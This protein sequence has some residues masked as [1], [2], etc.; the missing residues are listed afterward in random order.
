MVMMNAGRKL[1]PF[2]IIHE[3]TTA[4]KLI[5]L[6]TDRSMY[7]EIIRSVKAPLTVRIG[8]ALRKMLITL[9]G[10]RKCPRPKNVT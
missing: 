1:N 3:K 7:P 2:R 10:L 8:T 4:F 9:S 6:P 5:A